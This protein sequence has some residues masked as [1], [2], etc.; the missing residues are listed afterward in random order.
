MSKVYVGG[1]GTLL[2]LE[3]G[4]DLTG[5]TSATIEVRKLAT[6]ADVSLAATVSGTKVRHTSV[7]STFDVAGEW[8]LQAKVVLPS[9]TWRGETAQL[10][11]YKHFA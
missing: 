2:E 8:L 1:V 11:I 10:T 7:L 6:G 3:T 5:Y 4:Q 9:G